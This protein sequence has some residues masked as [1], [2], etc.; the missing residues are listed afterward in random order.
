MDKVKTHIKH[1]YY[2]QG[3]IFDYKGGGFDA[4]IVFIEGGFSGINTEYW[5]REKELADSP[6]MVIPFNGSSPQKARITLNDIHR[7]VFM[8]LDAAAQHGK[9]NIG[10]HGIR[11]EDADDYT[12]A[13][14][15]IKAVAEW[16]SMKPGAVESVTLV[17][18]RNCYKEHFDIIKEY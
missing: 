8:T 6:V 9:K 12:G 4:I 11:A 1:L 17:D 14:Y 5:T 13:E 16:L 3:D 18:M 15:T 2:A 10:F 7:L